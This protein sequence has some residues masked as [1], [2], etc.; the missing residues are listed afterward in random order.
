MAPADVIAAHG[1]AWQT[2]LIEISAMQMAEL[3]K[4]H[5]K[6]ADAKKNLLASIFWQEV[7]LEHETLDL[8]RESCSDVLAPNAHMPV[9]L[10]TL[11]N[12]LSS[13]KVCLL[14]PATC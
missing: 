7:H 4:L 1:S 3:S 14:V 12:D 2:L 10:S 6:P 11:V 8:V 5:A 13:N 9:E